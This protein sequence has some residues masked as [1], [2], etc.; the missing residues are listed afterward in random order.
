VNP[1]GGVGTRNSGEGWNL[2]RDYMKLEAVESQH[3]ARLYGQWWPH[4]FVDCHTTDGSIHA[5]DLNHDALAEVAA[6]I[7]PTVDEVTAPMDHVPAEWANNL[8]DVQTG[9]VAEGF[10]CGISLEGFNDLKE[11]DLIESYDIE[12]IKQRL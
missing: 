4:V 12:E 10:E 8:V 3:L 11:K 2:N 6:N 5:Y 7:G 1:P 9:E